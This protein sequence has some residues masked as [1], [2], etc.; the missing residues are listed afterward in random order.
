MKGDFRY[1]SNT[2]FD[3]FPWPQ[4]PSSKSVRAVASAAR[5]LRELRQSLRKKHDLS[6]RDLYRSL[7]QPGDH[8]LRDAQDALDGAVRGAYGFSAKADILASLAKLNAACAA[9]ESAGRSVQGPGFPGNPQ[10]RPRFVTEDAI[11]MA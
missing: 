5:A 7:E 10:D 8:P 11:R 4:A 6:L 1:T 3:T 2:V 9:A